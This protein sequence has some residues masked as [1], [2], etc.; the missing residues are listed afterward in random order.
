MRSFY[1]TTGDGVGAYVGDGVSNIFIYGAGVSQRKVSAWADQSGYGHHLT[2]AVAALQPLLARSAEN[3]SDTVRFDASGGDL[4]ASAA[5]VLNQPED[6][7]AVARVIT[8]GSAGV[9]DWVGRPRDGRMVLGN[10]FAGTVAI[11]AGR[12]SLHRGRSGLPGVRLL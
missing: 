2:Q 1:V 4:L 11:S 3:G 8:Q 5:F 12:R 6:V 9:R 7:F 10:I